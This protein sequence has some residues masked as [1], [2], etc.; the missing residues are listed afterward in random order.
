M[1]QSHR[2]TFPAIRGIQAQ[3][4]YYVTMCP[5]RL[6]PK[7]FIFD[8]Q[9]LQPELRAQRV[10]N[11]ARIPELVSYMIDN[12]SEYVFSAL[13]ASIDAEVVFTPLSDDEEHFNIG[14]LHVPMSARF[15]INDGQHRRAAIEAAIKVKP[16][17]GNESIAVVFF[18]DTGLQRSQQMFADLNRYA[19]RPTQSLNIL[20]DHRDA[21]A[22]LA[23]EISR[24]VPIFNG[25]TEM[26]K[27]TI[28]N[29]STKIFTLS[30][31][32]R[33]TKELL[34]NIVDMRASR[35]CVDIATQYWD[36]VSQY[37]PEWQLVKEGKLAPA[38]F[39][40][41][42]ISAHTVALVALGR[43]GNALLTHH[44][45]SWTKYIP[46]LK[47]IDWHR[48]NAAVWEGRATIGGRISNSRNSVLLIGNVLKHALGLPLLP[49]EQK[50]EDA[51]GSVT[52][53]YRN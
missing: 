35:E 16:E 12:P 25:L 43:L 11:K 31:I 1:F 50:A 48:H 29:R 15:V 32:H 28:S 17:L 14:F 4:E 46:R 51:V 40:R 13:T 7:L 44:P 38:D 49:E 52:N 45:D 20:Y 10:L 26:E 24:Q 9:E 18:V 41:D 23:R 5:L 37:I 36:L 33:A 42:F 6:I 19:V 30:G 3:R 8:D 39:R 21:F 2:Y 27:S 34:A 47:S 53:P 22:R